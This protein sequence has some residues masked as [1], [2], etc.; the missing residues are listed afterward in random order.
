VNDDTGE[1]R[2]DLTRLTEINILPIEM[3]ELLFKVC[4]NLGVVPVRRECSWDTT[5]VLLLPSDEWEKV[6]WEK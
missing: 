5:E 1:K 2:Y 4:K 6:K 3:I